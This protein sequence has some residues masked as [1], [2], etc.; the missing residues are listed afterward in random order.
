MQG[1]AFT[2]SMCSSNGTLCNKRNATADLVRTA[3][4]RKEFSLF[5]QVLYLKVH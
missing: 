1:F 4:Q 3:L 2:T 5:G